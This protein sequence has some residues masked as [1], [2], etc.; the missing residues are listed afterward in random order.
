MREAVVEFW[1]EADRPTLEQVKDPAWLKLHS[2]KATPGEALADIFERVVEAQVVLEN[3]AL[4]PDLERHR[5]ADRWI[6]RARLGQERHCK[7]ALRAH[8]NC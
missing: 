5:H 1:I 6:C 8:L 3:V 7:D 4:V 2:N